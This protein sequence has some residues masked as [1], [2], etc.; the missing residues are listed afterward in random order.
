MPNE[1]E[2]PIPPPEYGDMHSNFLLLWPGDNKMRKQ[3]LSCFRILL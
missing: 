3:P 2:V 1:Y